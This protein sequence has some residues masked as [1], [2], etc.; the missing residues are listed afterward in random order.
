MLQKAKQL[1]KRL[2]AFLLAVLITAGTCLSGS[3]PVH[4]A[5]GTIQY[6]AGA[7]INYGSYSTSRMTFDGSNTA[8]CVEPLQPTPSSGTYAYTLLGNDSPIRKALYYLNGGYG[9]DKHIKNQYLGGWSDDNSYVIGHLV[10]AYIYAGY[11][12]D[13]GAFHGAPQNY[14]DKSV[15]IANAIKG[16][17]EPPAT[18]KAFIVPGNNDQTLVGSWYQVPYG[19]IELHKASA[20][21]AVSDGNGNYSLKGAEYGIYQGENMV[22]KLTT[23]QNGYSKSG[24]LESGSYTVKELKASKGYII[25]VTAHNVTVEPEKTSSLNVTEVPQNN[26]MDLLLQKLDKELKTAQPQGKASLAEAQFTVKFY[27]EQSDKDPA[28][29]GAKPARTWIFKTDSEGKVKFSKNYLVSGDEFYTQK[30]GKTPCLPLGTV[31]VQETKAP[32]GYLANDTVFVQKITAGGKA[33]TVSCYNASSVEEQV[34]RGSVKL[35]KRDFETKEA[36]PQGGATL[37][38]AAFTITS[39]NEN[40][41]VV[42][43]KTYTKN[44]IVMSLTTDSKGSVSTKKD[45][46]PF[47]HYRADETKAPEGYLNEGKLSVEFDI[48]KNGEIVD[49]TSEEAAISNQVI[50]GDLELVKVADGEQK[51]LSDIPFSITSV[52]TGESHTIVTDKN[53]YASTAS[54]WNKHTHNTNQGKTSEDGIWFGTSKPN[55]SKGALPYD[56]YIIEEQRCKANESMDLLKFE[57]TIYKDSVSVDLG[58]LTDDKIEIGTTALDKNTGTH[59]SKPEKKV[60]LIDTVEYSGLKKDQKYQVIGTL[61]DAETGEAILIDEKPVTAETEFTAKMSS[62]SVEVIFTFDAT[63][64]E[65]KTTVIFEKLHQNGQKLAV[66]ADLKD[67]DQQISFPEI[68]T[69]AKDSDTEENIANADEKVQLTDTIFF[70]GLVPNLEYVATGRLVDV[71]TEEPLL[72][73]DTPITAQTTFTPKASEGTV[74]VVFEFNGSSLKGKNTVIYESVTQEEKEVGMHADPEFKD[75]QMFFPEIGT[76]ASCP[77]TDS[78]MAIPKK[79]LTIV[80]TVSYHLVPGKEYKLTGTLMDKESGEPLLIDEKPVTSELVFTPE[81]AEGTVELSFTF[82]ASALKGKTIVAFES[83]SYQE[84]EIAVHT[85]I[86]STPQSI[87]FPEIGTKASCPETDSQMA[88]AKKEVTITDT[89]SYKHL[90]PGKEYKLTGTLMDKE[91]GEP[92]LVDKKSV[93]SE[94]VFTPETA[95]GTVELSFTFDA[96]ALEGKTI[97]AFESLSYKGKELTV[98]A[99]IESE[100]QTIYFPEIGTKASCPETGS[101]MA[102]AK[103]ELTIVDTVTYQRLVPGKEYKLTG[104]LMDQENGE[105]LLVDGKTVTSEL[106]FTPETADG[107]VELSFTFD[108]STLK[109]KTI[110]A[111]ES[112]SY[113]EKEVAVHADIESK[114]QSIYIPEIGTTAKDGKD[115]DQETLAEKETQIIDTVKYKD[116]VAGGPSYRL[117]GTLMD[118][119]TGKEIL[120]DGKPVTAET[121]FKPEE[122]S[123][124]VDVT[125]AFDA[126]ELKG[127]DVVVF[128]KLFVTVK[129]EDKAKELEVTS[130]EDIKAKSQTVKLTEVPTE[131]KE[132]DISS[133]VKTGDDAPILLYICIAAGSL[134]LI[135]ISGLVLYWRRKHQK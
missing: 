82:D 81:E 130:H 103:K 117:V 120:I 73:G 23:D 7:Q 116:L 52:T 102:P 114:P 89:V 128:E 37:E 124:S 122:S 119:E 70:K 26:P 88:P 79:D 19:Y 6:Q 20:N 57:V 65:G 62:G 3:V 127:H 9:Y 35:Q 46:L 101:Q 36:E 31:T 8:Y 66:H 16:L 95:D 45:A 123:G 43:G 67:T 29:G 59:M 104:T 40:P 94:L 106:V 133:P 74:D 83:V 75:Q 111:F 92:L 5:D 91:S 28:V 105:F 69:K 129:E 99:D 22:A 87:Y 109:G 44:Q 98:H 12:S 14:I 48:T 58:T 134:L 50:R 18:F 47:G 113:Q 63:S 97:V 90:V 64:L 80:D 107:S 13:S 34:Y 41:V 53:G 30:D 55:D 110:V 121:T 49:L 77:E 42:D 68:G 61:M 17:P 24:E 10:V 39:L 93:T 135:I 96:S 115:G 86:E 54:K 4:A 1:T 125:F 72:D 76:K 112:V 51:R 118:K 2:S 100:P 132:P 33:E 15:E 71:E 32:T 21:A 11:A 131:P 108:A 60:T 27:T 25:D 126:T 38:N 84:K 78:Q 85:D 56:T